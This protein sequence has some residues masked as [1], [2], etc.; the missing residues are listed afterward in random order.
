VKYLVLGAVA[1]VLLLALYYLNRAYNR[2]LEA[3]KMQTDG[4]ES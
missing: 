1:A 3:A 4:E 2:A